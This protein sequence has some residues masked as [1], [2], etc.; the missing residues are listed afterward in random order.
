M[1]HG[2]EQFAP[3]LL[4]VACEGVIGDPEFEQ[5]RQRAAGLGDVVGELVQLHIALVADDQPLVAVEHA[6]A[7]RHVVERDAHAPIAQLHAPAK[8][9]AGQRHRQHRRQRGE[10]SR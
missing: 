3:V 4:R 5:A 2:G 1:R 10:E 7:L 6:Q 9:R 8:D